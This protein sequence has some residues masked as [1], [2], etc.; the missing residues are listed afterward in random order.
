MI[1]GLS[2]VPPALPLLHN[3][4]V[5]KGSWK[6]MRKTLKEMLPELR[7]QS[8]VYLDYQAEFGRKS[9]N[10]N[11]FDVHLHGAMDLLTR[12][13]CNELPCR[14]AAAE[15]IARSMG[16]VADRVWLTD[17]L[18]D[19]FVDFGKPTN[20]KLDSILED[21]M[22]LFTLVPLI[23]SGVVKFRTPTITACRS[24]METFYQQV[25]ETTEVLADSFKKE[26]KIK[27][28]SNGFT[29]EVGT[30]VEPS[31]QVT[32]FNQA[33]PKKKDFVHWWIEEEV[34]SVMWIAREASFTRGSILSNSRVGLAGLLHKEGRT[35][36]PASLSLL[37]RER[38]FSIPWVSS[39]SPTQIVELREEASNALPQFRE[40]MFKIMSTK[41]FEGRSPEEQILE[42]REQSEHVRAEL[43]RTQKNS[44]RYWK[45]TYGLL[46]LSLSAYGVATDQVLPGIGG[47]LP[48]IQLLID[49][50]SSYSSV[51]DSHLSKPAYVLLKAQD[52]LSHSR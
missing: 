15:R 9:D 25:N 46:G 38:E 37:D 30:C 36:D 21:L 20:D 7:D 45:T 12:S 24:C 34:R 47:L 51:V 18:S 31:I 26:F 42:L 13:G 2:H 6:A 1:D 8:E 22:V 3:E 28:T 17:L 33:K 49:H 11:S 4:L 41:Q 27:K 43:L 10:F 29:A 19:K 50:N 35:A 40:I 14:V 32:G 52:I 39:L 5:G 16:L 48:I 44:A 23:T